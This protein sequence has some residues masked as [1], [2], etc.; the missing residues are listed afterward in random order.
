MEKNIFEGKL[1]RLT[2]DDPEEAAKPFSHWSRN[3][4]YLRLL[5]TSHATMV[6]VKQ[7][8]KW[9]EEDL[10]KD[11]ND[12]FFFHIH[13]RS[14]DRL[15]GFIGLF[16]IHVA[17]R[18]AWVGIGIGDE[19][20]WG[21]GYGTDAMR[22]VLCY[23]FQELNLHRVSLGVFA[24]NLRA[25]R[26][27]EKSGFKLEGRERNVLYRDGERADALI[28]GILREEWEALQ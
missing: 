8:T 17:H 10:D 28:M 24:Y 22:T 18:D 19:K 9:I 27:Y 5:D 14:D 1:I 11:S 25:I 2:M 13:T 20:Y 21:K 23:A 26:A 7:F 6:S 4:E 16:D 12:N 3:S 15:I